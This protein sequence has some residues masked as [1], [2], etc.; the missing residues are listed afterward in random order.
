MSTKEKIKRNGRELY[1]KWLQDTGRKGI[2]VAQ[3][4]GTTEARTSTWRSGQTRPSLE[5][6]DALELLSDGAVPADAW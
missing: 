2:W 1:T 3:Q 5:M 4:L 6:A